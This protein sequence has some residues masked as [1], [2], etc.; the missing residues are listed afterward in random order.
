MKSALTIRI[1][2]FGLKNDSVISRLWF[3]MHIG[4]SRPSMSSDTVYMLGPNLFLMSRLSYFGKFWKRK[5]EEF[6]LRKE[7]K[8]EIRKDSVPT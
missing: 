7:L 8:C 6:T 2:K 4:Q 5:I 3:N 1:E